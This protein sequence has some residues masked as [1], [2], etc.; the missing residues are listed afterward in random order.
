MNVQP[1]LCR[2]WFEPKL[3]VSNAQA[4]M[5]FSNRVQAFSRKVE[6]GYKEGIESDIK[7]DK[8]FQQKRTGTVRNSLINS[9][10]L[11]MCQLFK[12]YN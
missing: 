10:V 6:L 8:E 1:G 7:H 4:Q 11:I 5:F 2:T 12:L 9:F 3:L